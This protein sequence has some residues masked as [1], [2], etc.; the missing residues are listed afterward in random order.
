MEGGGCRGATKWRVT[1]RLCN[2]QTE[3]AHKEVGV[4]GIPVLVVNHGMRSSPVTYRYILKITVIPKLR[5]YCDT[6]ITIATG[7]LFIT[8][9]CGSEVAM[10]PCY[11]NF[12]V[13][14]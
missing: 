1:A 2:F 12:E 4:G 10:K 5:N 8:Y 11:A 3:M 7:S 13:N 14:T 9:L 6:E